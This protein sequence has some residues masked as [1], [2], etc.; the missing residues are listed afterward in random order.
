MT[1]SPV[2]TFP[3]A[4]GVLMACRVSTAEEYSTALLT[5]RVD[6]VRTSCGVRVRLATPA[7]QQ[8]CVWAL[9]ELGYAVQG[10][11][12]LE[13]ESGEALLVTGWDVDALSARANHA[14]G[15][16]R[17]LLAEHERLAKDAIDTYRSCVE[18]LALPG[19][20]ATNVALHEF[21]LRA[22]D[23]PGRLA[24]A[25]GADGYWGAPVAAIDLEL[26]P[27]PARALLRRIGRLD[28]I[29][30]WMSRIFYQTAWEAIDRYLE[31][32]EGHRRSHELS[33]EFAI[34]EASDMAAG[35]ID[36]ARAALEAACA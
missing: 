8:T 33:A 9:R 29:H 13:Q 12:R 3:D 22:A 16:V 15:A 24:R 11:G 17:G 26:A 25:A 21:T 7:H 18:D 14:E 1:P 20:V 28:I 19:H 4:L 23:R 10:H 32:R 36:D 31:N 35:Q 34:K 30:R 6:E 5:K 27:E 2:A